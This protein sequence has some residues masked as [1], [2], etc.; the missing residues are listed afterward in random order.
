MTIASKTRLLS[1]Q[2]I[3]AGAPFVE[4]STRSD[5][6]ATEAQRLGAPFY[7]VGNEE[8]LTLPSLPFF[9]RQG[10]PHQEV[11]TRPDV[12]A[13]YGKGW[14]RSG[15]PYVVRFA[16]TSTYTSLPF[17]TRQGAPHQEVTTRPDVD[18]SYGKGWLRS[19]APYV[20]RFAG[21]STYTSLPFN[22]RQGAPF[23]DVTAKASIDASEFDYTRLGAP[24]WVRYDG[25]TPPVAFDATRFFIIF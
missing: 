19:G 2:Y 22:T 7:G 24:F 23:R 5:F 12:D 18:A 13:S 8:T 4:V 25:S 1:F 20:V 9:T 14:L 21:T 15:A 10:A 3:R 6:D 17:F 11:T 16:G